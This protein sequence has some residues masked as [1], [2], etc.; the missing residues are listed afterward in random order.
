MFL[1]NKRNS[2][3]LIPSY[4][5]APAVGQ[6]L[7]LQ[8]FKLSLLPRSWVFETNQPTKVAFSVGKEIYPIAKGNSFR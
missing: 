2:L 8:I 1:F 7:P 6:N 5:S 4:S 3:L